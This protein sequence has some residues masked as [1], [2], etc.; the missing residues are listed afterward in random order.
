M[1]GAKEVGPWMLINIALGTWLGVTLM[2]ILAV[3]CGLGLIVYR[4]LML[5][6]RWMERR[7]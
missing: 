5:P 4:L 1:I 6:T 3:G 7:R 2:T